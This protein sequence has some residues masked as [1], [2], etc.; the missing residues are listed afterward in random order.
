VGRVRVIFR[1][2]D[3]FHELAPEPLVYIEWFTSLNTVDKVSGMYSVSPSTSNHE[4]SASVIPITALVRTCHLVPHWG[5]AINLTWTQENVLD[6]AKCTRF[7]VN[8]YVRLSDFVL[9][10]YVPRLNKK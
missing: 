10:H 6:P 3:I 9:L 8:P 4:R 5:R 1:A 2:P 7:Y